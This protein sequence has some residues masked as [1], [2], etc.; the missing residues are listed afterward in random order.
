LLLSTAEV[1]SV[2]PRHLFASQ[3]IAGG[4]LDLLMHAV[5]RAGRCQNLLLV[6]SGKCSCSRDHWVNIVWLR[7]FSLSTRIIPESLTPTTTRSL[8][9]TNTSSA[10]QSRTLGTMSDFNSDSDEDIKRAI[11]L[12]LQQ[13]SPESQNSKIINLVSENEDDDLDA[14]VTA[15]GITSPSQPNQNADSENGISAIDYGND[16][17]NGVAPSQAESPT[18]DQSL[19]IRQDP[20]ATNGILGSLNRK[21]M[22]EERRARTQRKIAQSQGSKELDSK[23]RKAPNSPPAPHNRESRQVMAKLSQEPSLG[24]DKLDNI[25]SSSHSIAPA[26]PATQEMNKLPE[27]VSFNDQQKTRAPGIQYPDGVIKKTW[28][29]GYPRQGDDIKIEEVLQKDDLELA[30]LSSYLIDPAWVE[31]KLDSKTRVIW[32]LQEK[33]EA[34][35]SGRLNFFFSRWEEISS[36]IASALATRR[37][38]EFKLQNAN[39]SDFAQE[40]SLATKLISTSWE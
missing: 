13:P 1:G 5:S 36:Q 9:F 20:P 15:K 11:A 37:D 6:R 3:N 16:N 10:R 7:S 38:Q 25:A 12:S 31:T 14:P 27:V 17:E 29:H 4:D 26:T 39:S 19:P 2:L 18:T 32:V 33:D 35:V 34:E 28:V 40:L 21:K 22:E 8:K 24:G 23:K 30:V